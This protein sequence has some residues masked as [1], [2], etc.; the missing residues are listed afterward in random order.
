MVDKSD[1]APSRA[2]SAEQW[3]ETELWNFAHALAL[4]LSSGH[5]AE[6]VIYNAMRG[7]VIA[8]SNYAARQFLRCV[9][10]AD[11]AEAERGYW[12]TRAET[13]ELKVLTFHEEIVK[14]GAACDG[15]RDALQA[16]VT[17]LNL[18]LPD[19]E[20][21]CAMEH[22]HG[23]PYQGP[24]LGEELKAAEKLLLSMKEPATEKVPCPTCDGPRY[25]RLVIESRLNQIIQEAQG[26][27][28][29]L[30]GK[31]LETEKGGAN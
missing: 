1:A 18:A 27:L 12:Q 15:L 19:I 4:D 3:L 29:A 14:L 13:A 30:P 7:A 22:I 28:A 5:Q 16:L 26:A 11:K 9:E 17:K 10:R 2:E 20:N 23:R 31:D 25:S 8:H 24:Q 21:M 6:Q